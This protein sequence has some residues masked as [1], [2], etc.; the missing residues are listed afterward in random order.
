MSSKLDQSLEEIQSA[1]RKSAGGR[2]RNAPR[3]SRPAA[4]PV[5]GIS[6]ATKPA[7]GG[8]KATPATKAAPTSGDSKIIVSGLVSNDLRAILRFATLTRYSPKT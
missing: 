4:A 3:A 2:R 1:S 6:K 8:G 5:G 7:R